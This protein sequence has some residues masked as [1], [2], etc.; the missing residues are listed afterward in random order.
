MLRVAA[1]ELPETLRLARPG[2]MMAFSKRD[3]VAPGYVEAVRAARAAGFEP[4]VRLAGGRAAVFHS[5]TLELAHA[6][7]EEEPRVRIHERFAFTAGIVARALI[8]LGIDARVGEVPGEYCPGRWSVNA[9]GARKLAGLGQ[10]IVAG[11]SHTGAVL[12]VSGADRVR[13]ALEPVYLAL[14]LSWDP[15]TVGAVV[16]SNGS[17]EGG[18]AWEAVRDALVAEYALVYDLE[19]ASLDSGTVALA[20]RLAPEHRP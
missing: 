15:S 11:G 7:P 19:P 12:V 13:S 17:D 9:E 16:G 14:G 18:R 6:V 20:R 10:R 5:E 1:G 8:R 4:I 2:T 3:V